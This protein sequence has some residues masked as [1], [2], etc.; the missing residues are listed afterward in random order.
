MT[1]N[2]YAARPTT[3][4]TKGPT[5]DGGEALEQVVLHRSAGKKS[6][7]GGTSPAGI[8]LQLLPSLYM[9]WYAILYFL[10]L[11]SHS[12]SWLLRSIASNSLTKSTANR[13]SGNCE[14]VREES[15]NDRVGRVCRDL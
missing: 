11:Q 12:R 13:V 2:V 6:G 10:Q 9:R 15:K 3:T 4:T 14:L 7:I 5:G 8:F 1:I